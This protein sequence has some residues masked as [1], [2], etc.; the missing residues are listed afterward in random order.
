M[1]TQSTDF[2]IQP[3]LCTHDIEG[4]SSFYVELFGAEEDMRVPGSKGPFFVTLRLG[5][6]SLGLV[7][8]KRG[9]DPAPG[10]VVMSVFV[11]SVDDLLP[12]VKPAGGKIHGKAKNMPW[13]HR[14]AHITDPDGNPIN[15][16]QL[17]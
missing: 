1:S 10:R 6:A 15:L 16:T 14:V 17:L 11:E 3:N 2:A 12:R 5:Q 7:T 4:L 9:A 8:P 13:G